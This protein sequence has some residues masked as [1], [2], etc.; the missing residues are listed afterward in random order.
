[1][2]MQID[3]VLQACHQISRQIQDSF[4]QLMIHYVVH[5]E[6]QRVEALGL[7]GQEVL[8]HPAAQTALHLLTRARHSEE[9][10][11]IGVAVARKPVLFGLASHDTVLA[12]CSIN[13]DQY[14]NIKEARRHACHLAWHAIDA[15]E[16]GNDPHNVVGSSR[17]V[18]VRRRGVLDLAGANIRA[19]IFAAVLGALQGDRDAVR[20]I[21]YARA[22]NTLQTMPSHSPENYPYIIAMEAAELALNGMEQDLPRK[23]HV[24][25]ALR[26]ASNIGKTFDQALLRQWLAFSEPAQDMAWRG[27]KPEE[28]L[29]SAINTSDD[30]YVR[31]IGYLVS[32]VTGIK[33]ASILLIRENY[34]PFADDSFNEKLHEKIVSQIFEDVIAQGLK[35]RSVSPFIELANQ[36]NLML[37][38]GRMVGWCASALHASASAFENAQANGKE[39]EWAARREFEGERS[40]TTWESLKDIGLKIIGHYREGGNV[41][42]SQLAEMCGT[43]RR[44]GR[45][46]SSIEMTMRD[47]AYQRDITAARKLSLQ[48][49]AAV[50]KKLAPSSA[51]ATPSHTYSTPAL[52]RTGA[53]QQSAAVRE[54]SIPIE[55]IDKRESAE[56]EGS[57]Q[58]D[59]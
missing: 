16:Y 20:K 7:A 58:R 26:I 38:E 10:T 40:K 53:R 1:M 48:P 51:P 56:R 9:S 12:L 3:T 27:Y 25:T 45:V 18:L 24:E 5:H 21:G 36:Q 6:G 43:D 42:M 11:L 46:K 37:I 31:S 44:F 50:A 55:A 13:I 8:H 22:M 59:R 52:G 41:T 28:I 2:P 17:E 4:K 29:S 30:T 34:S 14:T 15:L 33:P 49:S 35:Q 57:E 39:A 32:E 19:D 54:E 23:K 47:P